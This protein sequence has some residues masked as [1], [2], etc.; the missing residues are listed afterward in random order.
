L[1]KHLSPWSEIFAHHSGGNGKFKERKDFKV[2]GG[3]KFGMFFVM[4]RV[5]LE[6][7]VLRIL[8]EIEGWRFCSDWLLPELQIM[9][10][11]G[12]DESERRPGRSVVRLRMGPS[13]KT[14]HLSAS[15]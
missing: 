2:L 8:M 9:V 4:L 12:I 6:E 5:N 11:A 14:T 3:G 13:L 15:N 1:E 7:G 10:P